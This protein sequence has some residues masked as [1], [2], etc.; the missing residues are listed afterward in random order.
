ML[1]L[2]GYFFKI[3]NKSNSVKLK[4]AVNVS[5]FAAFYGFCTHLQNIKNVKDRPE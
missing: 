3:I 1:N 5:H 2:L 4:C